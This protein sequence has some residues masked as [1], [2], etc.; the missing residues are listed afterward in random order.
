MKTLKYV[1]KMIKKC[2]THCL[3]V[4]K[5]QYL[6]ACLSVCDYFNFLLQ[7]SEFFQFILTCD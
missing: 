7:L 6:A 4:L 5:S 2:I 1:E 3:Y